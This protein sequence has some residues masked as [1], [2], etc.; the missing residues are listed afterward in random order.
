MLVPFCV[1]CTLVTRGHH[2]ELGGQLC[3]LSWGEYGM[4]ETASIHQVDHGEVFGQL[5]PCTARLSL[6]HLVSLNRNVNEL[7]LCAEQGGFTQ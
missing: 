3:A 7:P 6:A 2:L 1:Q 4:L 5:A